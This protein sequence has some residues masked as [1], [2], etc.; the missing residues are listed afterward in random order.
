MFGH[1]I[2]IEIPEPD[3]QF[4][5]M[6]NNKKDNYS[7]NSGDPNSVLNKPIDLLQAMASLSNSCQDSFNFKYQPFT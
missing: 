4:M 3:P 2:P 6:L 1:G 5:A 7:S